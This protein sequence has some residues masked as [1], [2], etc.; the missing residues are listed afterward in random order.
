[1]TLPVAMVGA[2]WR[3]AGAELR[4]RMAALAEAAE[5]VHSLREGGHLGGAACVV[6][7]SRTEWVL[8][9]DQP[10]WAASL[11]RSALLAQVPGLEPAAVQARCGVSAVHHLL[12]VAAGL[13]SV[14]EGEGA[15]GRQVLRAFEQARKRGWSDGRLNRVA[16]E[17]ERLVHARRGVLPG[18][19]SRGVQGL[20]REVLLEAGARSV[21]VLGRGDFARAVSRSLRGAGLEDVSSVPRQALPGW[22]AHAPRFQAVVVCT[23]APR[24]WLE[25]PPHPAQ[26]L[27]VD[28]GSPPQVRSAPGWVT[29]GLD[30]L[31][32][33]PGVRLPESERHRLEALVETA[34]QSLVEGLRA[35]APASLLA[36]LD[37]ERTEFLHHQLPSLLE[38]IPSERARQVQRAVRAFTHR[39]LQRTREAQP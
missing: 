16:R 37:Q 36:A 9:S 4:A 27:C 11:L 33:R 6:T 8:T 13:D 5:P 28:A 35:P 22:L 38:G 31:L 32:A 2:A 23:A 15:V 39:L 20:V 30:Q 3:A 24:A 26:G 21:A 7:C 10:E 34:G 17:V 1:M 14:A 12:G 19:P 25:L 18:A 29:C